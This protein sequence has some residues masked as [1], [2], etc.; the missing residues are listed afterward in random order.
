MADASEYDDD[1]RVLMWWLEPMRLSV[2]EVNAYCRR[3]ALPALKA[4]RG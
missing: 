2:D 4:V 1:Q 3:V